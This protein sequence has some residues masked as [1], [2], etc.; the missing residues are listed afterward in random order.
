MILLFFSN[1]G[2]NKPYEKLWKYIKVN[3][4]KVT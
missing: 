3:N 2:F 1:E 4:N